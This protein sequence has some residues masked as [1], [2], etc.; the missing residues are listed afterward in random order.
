MFSRTLRSP[1]IPSLLAV[2]GD[3]AD[4]GVLAGAGGLRPV[5]R[6]GDPD[7]ALRDRAERAVE[8]APERLDAGADQPE[9]AEDL[10]ARTANAMS[11]SRPA[12]PKSSTFSTSCAGGR[13]RP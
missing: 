11:V 5:G 9:H 6:P 4:A 7:R 1:M 8:R 2:G 13:P 12:T 10:A 3:E